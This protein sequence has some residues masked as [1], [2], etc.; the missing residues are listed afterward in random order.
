MKK[1]QTNQVLGSHVV[2]STF[3]ILKPNHLSFE[4]EKWFPTLLRLYHWL[5]CCIFATFMSK[6]ILDHFKRIHVG[7][8]MHRDATSA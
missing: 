4:T 3:L 6:R 1:D 8:V 7:C 5:V 2:S